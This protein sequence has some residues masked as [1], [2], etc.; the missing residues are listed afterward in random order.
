MEGAFGCWC[1]GCQELHA[2]PYPGRG[3]GFNG[4]LERPTFSPSFKIEW[5][6]LQ[7]GVEA[8]R[9]CHFT[10]T[11]GILHFH[12]D[13]THSLRGDVPLPPLPPDLSDGYFVES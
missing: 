2:L 10:L 13:S 11:A 4:D 12:N 1:P 6:G 7:D 8:H 5:H 3:W 9:V